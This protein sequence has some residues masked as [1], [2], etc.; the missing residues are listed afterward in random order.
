MLDNYL[1]RIEIG[2]R[3]GVISTI[4]IQPN[5]PICEFR[6]N[7]ITFDNLSSLEEPNDA[8]QI[9]PNIYLS[10]AGN[11]TDHI[12]HSCNPNCMVHTV[13]NRAIL[14]SL[15]L[16]MPNSEITFDY[17]SSSTEDPNTWQ[18]HCT[19]GSF[20]CRKSIS[21]FHHLD[22]PLQ[23][24]YKQKGIAALFIREKIFLRK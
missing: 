16:I 20:N 3:K 19:C 24:E 22:E 1:K 15:Y 12:R 14:Y 11:L 17:S 8:L 6:G 2:K 18:M 21:G 10:P 9:G 13:G 23:N 5:T 4:I 7:V